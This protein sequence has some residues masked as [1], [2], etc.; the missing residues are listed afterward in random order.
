MNRRYYRTNLDNWMIMKG[1]SNSQM[2]RACGVDE[3][4]VRRWR[5]D[6]T[7][8][9]LEQVKKILTILGAKFDDLFGES[10]K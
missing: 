7:S 2:A 6:E 9:K 1:V 8:P 3:K 10:Q 4:T 5:A